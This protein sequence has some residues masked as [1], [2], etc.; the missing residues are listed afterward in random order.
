MA[1]PQLS[2]NQTQNPSEAKGIVSEL[3]NTG[4]QMVKEAVG[5]VKTEISQAVSGVTDFLKDFKNEL[6]ELRRAPDIVRAEFTNMKK[7]LAIAWSETKNYGSLRERLAAMARIANTKDIEY[8]GAD[9]SFMERQ[10]TEIGGMLPDDLKRDI[11]TKSFALDSVDGV[12]KLGSFIQT[13]N[14]DFGNA[15]LGGNNNEN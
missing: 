3:V 9:E 2:S 6:E 15:V 12:I 7:A 14:A 1:W 11:D 8:E 13:F 4:T 10:L 5:G